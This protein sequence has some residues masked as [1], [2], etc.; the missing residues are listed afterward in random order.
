[1]PDLHL[2]DCFV[3]VAFNAEPFDPAAVPTWTN[4]SSRVQAI[5]SASRGRQY[6]LDQNQTG[7]MDVSWVNIDEALNPVNTGSPY[8]PNVQPYRQILARCMWPNGGT[9]N[10]LNLA[11]NGTN[12]GFESYTAGAA[13]PWVTAIGAGVT[14]TV[15]AATAFQGTKSLTYVVTNGGGAQGISWTVPCIPGRQYTSSIYVIQQFGNTTGIS[16]VGIGAGSST[17]T[18][19]AYVRL[20]VTFTATQPTHTVVMQSSPTTITGV[21]N[22]D[23]LQH[24]PGAAASTFTTTGPLIRNIWTRGYV[25]RW[26]VQWDETG[27][28]GRSTTPCVGPFAILQ[29]AELSTALTSSILTKAPAY[30]W[31]LQE[32]AGS[33]VFVESSG[34]GG[35]PLRRLD[36]PFGPGTTYAPGTTMG[37]PGDPGGVGVKLDGPQVFHAPNTLLA[38]GYNRTTPA[39]ALGTPTLPFTVSVALWNSRTATGGQAVYLA[40]A[41]QPDITRPVF[42][43]RAET[44]G[45]LTFQS[46]GAGA[47]IVTDT[48]ADGLPHM[49]A[50][51]VT[52]SAV[53]TNFSAYVDGVS[54]GSFSSGFAVGTPAANTMVVGGY[55]NPAG[56]NAGPNPPGGVYAKVALWNRGLSAGEIADMYAAGTGY[57]GELEST[58]IAR[59]LSLG[60]Y[61]GPTSISAGASVMGADTVMQGDAV[62]AASQQASDSAFGNFY[63]SADGIAYASRNA[64]YLTTTSAYTFG[65][66]VAGGEYPYIGDVLFDFDPQLVLNVADVTRTGGIVGHAEDTTGFSQKRYGRKNFTRTVD[67][68]SDNETVDAATWVVANRKATQMRV[69][70]VTFDPA[71]TRV[72]FGDGTIWPMVLTLEIGTRVTVRRRPKSA[73]AGAGITMSGDFFIESIDH[74]DI[75]FEAGTWLTTLQLSPVNVAQPW[76]LQDAVYGQLGVTTVLGF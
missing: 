23:A 57:A 75:D 3:G 48:W 63:E 30:F 1:M 10:L 43:I 65:E 22:V 61:V 35:P 7:A 74:H 14:P 28:E 58:R 20:S 42:F 62:L 26:P 51:V 32:P 68:A 12:P 71:A 54:V 47:I 53:T 49:Y 18:P 15:V 11:Y 21:V 39:I 60:G 9:G 25:E 4:L 2:P 27:F 5:G 13:V 56:P 46:D 33:T 67:I 38:T 34:K 59:Y 24:E 64:R 17:T 66:N 8:Y 31:S 72:P 16:V 40:F 70:S 45:Q 44:T 37:I 6:E 19:V 73:N 52:V 29:N 69:A 50:M 36:G 76:I 55:L 41:V